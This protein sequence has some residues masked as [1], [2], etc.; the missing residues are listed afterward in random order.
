MLIR[1]KVMNT[2]TS[3]T[4]K[5]VNR[6]MDEFPITE[7]ELISLDER[8][9]ARHKQHNIQIKSQRLSQQTLNQRFD[10]N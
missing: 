3:L 2:P 10:L 5:S 8:L 9:I 1:E 4:K 6:L 7:A